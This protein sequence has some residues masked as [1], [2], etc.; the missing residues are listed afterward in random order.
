MSLQTRPG[1]FCRGS[2]HLS[3]NTIVSEL[4]GKKRHLQMHLKFGE[5][6]VW[7]IRAQWNTFK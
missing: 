6:T 1:R 2:K 5:K 7:P 3:G 4:R